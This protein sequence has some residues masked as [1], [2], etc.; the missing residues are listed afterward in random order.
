VDVSAPHGIVERRRAHRAGAALGLLLALA[1]AGAG[2]SPAAAVSRARASSCAPTVRAEL[3]ETSE[4]DA[5]A[6]RL[7]HG[8]S[9]HVALGGMRARPVVAESM[10]LI[11]YFDDRS[12]TT[13]VAARFCAHLR[14]PRL[15]Q[16]GISRTDRDIWIVV[17]APFEAPSG[18]PL[19]VA[20]DVLVGVNDARTHGHHCGGRWFPPAAPVRLVPLLTSVAQ[21]RS[22]EMA[23]RGELEHTGAD[24]SSPADRVE[25]AGYVARVVAENIA[26]GVQ[27]AGEA[28]QG[29][30]DSPGH[31]AN[32]M[33]PRFTE[34]GLG[35]AVNPS[36]PLQIYW[37]QL[38]A[39]PRLPTVA[40]R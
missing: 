33:D 4:L 14:D 39:L 2:A 38:L 15:S 31:C 24:G 29:W 8:D 12:L 27:N 6:W 36:A 11:G 34:M 17:A 23:G 25:R 32:I 5:V 28:V 7:A 20:R 22:A 30:L 26:G 37:T 40:R 13:A 3:R 16:V 1:G 9:L 19:T 18:D 10:H 21:R 35:F